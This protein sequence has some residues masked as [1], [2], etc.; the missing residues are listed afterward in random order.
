M[1]PL[2]IKISNSLSTIAFI[3]KNSHHAND[4]G[5]L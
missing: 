1:K 3:S 2:A 4:W 5:T